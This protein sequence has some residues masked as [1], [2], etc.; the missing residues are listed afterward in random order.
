M[1]LMEYQLVLLCHI[2]IPMVLLYQS[3]SHPK[4]ALFVVLLSRVTKEEGVN[5]V[6]KETL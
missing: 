3:S 5:Q 4:H 6:H 2:N 1:G